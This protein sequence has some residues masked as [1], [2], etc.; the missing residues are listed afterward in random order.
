M[1]VLGRILCRLGFHEWETEHLATLYYGAR[2]GRGKNREVR[3]WG[4]RVRR[5][6]CWRKGCGWTPGPDDQGTP[7]IPRSIEMMKA[8]L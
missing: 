4:H 6:G 5:V 1:V 2:K 7:R 8:G 3:E